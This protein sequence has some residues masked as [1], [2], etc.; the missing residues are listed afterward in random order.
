LM[1]YLLQQNAVAKSTAL[2]YSQLPKTKSFS[3]HA[4]SAQFVTGH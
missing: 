1:S 2:K 3:Y 4:L